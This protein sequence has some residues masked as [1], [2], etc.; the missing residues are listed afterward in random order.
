MTFK[1]QSLKVKSNGTIRF[2]IPGVLHMSQP[3]STQDN[4]LGCP[5]LE[6]DLKFQGHSRSNPTLV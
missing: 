5:N 1:V 4:A 6:S 2:F 3:F